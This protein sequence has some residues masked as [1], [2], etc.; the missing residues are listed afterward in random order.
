[1]D[2]L[3][4]AGSSRP[5]NLVTLN[6]KQYF[7]CTDTVHRNELWVSDGTDTGTQML[8]DIFPKKL[9]IT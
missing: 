4:G 7:T 3:Q 9:A 1:M 8:M 2:I 6:G 5:T